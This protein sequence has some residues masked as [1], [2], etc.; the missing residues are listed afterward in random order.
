MSRTQLDQIL[1]EIRAQRERTLSVLEDVTEEEFPIPTGM[2]RWTEVRRLLL[3]FGDHMREHVNQIDGIRTAIDRPLTMAQRMLAES[4]RAWG[5]VL[6]ST[7]GLTDDDLDTKPLDGWTLRETIA[8][9]AWAE[10]FYFDAVTEAL[11]QAREHKE[12]PDGES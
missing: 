10:Q 11:K 7:V 4:E 1:A 2:E 8:H 3:R 12:I 9:L 6:A 5:M